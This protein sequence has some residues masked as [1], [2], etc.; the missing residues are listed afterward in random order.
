MIYNSHSH[1]PIF[2]KQVYINIFT[3]WQ[4]LV[5]FVLKCENISFGTPLIVYFF[6]QLLIWNEIV[7]WYKAS[8]SLYQ[9]FWTFV[10]T[11]IFI[12]V[13]VLVFESKH[14]SNEWFLT[15]RRWKHIYGVVYNYRGCEFWTMILIVF[16][17]TFVVTPAF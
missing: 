15:L 1:N 11:L 9:T 8:E 17:T 10:N 4:I 2:V 6:S 7:N 14:F 5:F 3:F 12:I 16:V 13:L